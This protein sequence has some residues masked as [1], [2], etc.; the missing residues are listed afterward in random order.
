[1][2]TVHSIQGFCPAEAQEEKRKG[3]G[4]GKAPDGDGVMVMDG[5]V[6]KFLW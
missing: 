4:K 6:Q 1:M 2:I 5:E 3:K